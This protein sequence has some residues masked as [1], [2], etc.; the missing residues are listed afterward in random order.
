MALIRETAARPTSGREL[1][2]SFRDQHGCHPDSSLKGCHAC[3]CSC[4]GGSAE[5]SVVGNEGLIGIALLMGGE[6]TP[7]RAIVQSAGHA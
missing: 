5:I 6:T 7:S 3:S 4:Q 2:S 1:R